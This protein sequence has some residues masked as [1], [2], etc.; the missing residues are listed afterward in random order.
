MHVPTPNAHIQFLTF[1]PA[2]VDRLRVWTPDRLSRRQLDQIER[3]CEG[4]LHPVEGPAP[5]GPSPGYY[6]WKL[7]SEQPPLAALKLFARLDD[8][9][10]VNALEIAADVRAPDPVSNAALLT[11]FQNHCLQCGHRSTMV[12]HVYRRGSQA[13]GFTTRKTRAKGT[14]RTGTWLQCYNDRE[15]R[16]TERPDCCHFEYKF[17]SVQSTRRI[18]SSGSQSSAICHPRDLLTFDLG[19]WLASRLSFYVVDPGRLGRYDYNRCSGSRRQRTTDADVRRGT[20]LY[21]GLSRHED[22]Q[23]SLQ[24]FVDKYGRGPF[25][26]PF[27]P[28]LYDDHGHSHDLLSLIREGQPF[29]PS[30]P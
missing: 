21:D 8:G 24:R 23:H 9:A 22:G 18:R 6:R 27:S 13:T 4:G 29:P 2:Y 10:I 17:E 12:P 26:V 20:R 3:A 1:R 25:L 30:T 19:G 7:E 11:L 15:C 5:F 16:F 28:T 14:R